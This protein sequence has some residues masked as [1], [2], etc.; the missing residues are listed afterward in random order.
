MYLYRATKDPYLLEVAVDIVES[1]D[2]SCRTRCGYATVSFKDSNCVCVFPS[3]GASQN[4][5]TEH[6]RPPL[7]GETR[8]R[9]QTGQ[10]DGILLSVR[11]HKV[12]LP[13]V[14]SGQLYP[15]H[16]GPR[17]GHQHNQ[18][19]VYHR[20]RSVVLNCVRR[21]VDARA[22]KTVHADL[23]CQTGLGFVTVFSSR[24]TALLL[25]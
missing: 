15:Q 10:Q 11:D 1:I 14:R 5:S 13:H 6:N 18:R 20:F 23:L 21:L 25:F 19:T 17:D 22:E 7:P 24:D 2:H 9:P 16:R 3:G 12:S 8:E 4:F